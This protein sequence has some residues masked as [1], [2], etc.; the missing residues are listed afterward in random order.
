MTSLSR[1]PSLLGGVRRVLLRRLRC[2][3]SAV[4]FALVPCYAILPQVI[5]ISKG[6][7]VE[8]N[9]STA[10]SPL[11]VGEAVENWTLMAVITTPN[12]E[13]AAVFEDFTDLRGH[14]IVT[15]PGRSAVD[16]PKSLAA[17]A[18]TVGD[19][20]RG[21]TLEEVLNSDEDLLGREILSLPGD[22]DFGDVAACFP[23]ISRMFTYTFVGTRHSYDKV[24]F[25]YGG[26]SSAFDPAVLVPAIRD[27]RRNHAVADGLV[28]G[29]MPVVR[30]VYPE[31]SGAWTEM[32]A[33][34]PIRMVNGNQWAQP[35]W[36]RVAR[37]EDTRLK[38]VRY[39]DSYVPFPPRTD[40]PPAR[41]YQELLGMKADW[42][43]SLKA[44][45]QISV[46]DSHSPI[47]RSI[48]SCAR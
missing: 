17:S 39:F 25:S 12:G 11:R 26:R 3:A 2:T 10:R 46:P 14:L 48:P 16:L 42:E 27:L 15:T 8:T 32:L 45:M 47:W 22:P 43:S 35:V 20:Y 13:P 37:V 38:W 19:F 29:W 44:A 7:D 6:G 18:A 33:Y 40:Q 5:A 21:H 34:A 23:P 1:L 36:Y 31:G 41:F 30:S 9:T 4:V 28:G 24:G